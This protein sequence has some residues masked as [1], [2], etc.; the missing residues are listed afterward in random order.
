[1][2]KLALL[3][4]EL[5]KLATKFEDLR[6]H[7]TIAHQLSS[8]VHDLQPQP[9]ADNSFPVRPPGPPDSSPLKEPGLLRQ[10]GVM[11]DK[12]ATSS[13]T[14]HPSLLGQE[15]EHQ[16]AQNIAHIIRQIDHSTRARQSAVEQLLNHHLD[17]RDVPKSI[18]TFEHQ[19]ARAK[20][21]LEG[22]ASK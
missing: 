7:R 1:L 12:M 9:P 10:L 8:F 20:N 22:C 21:D 18:D 14:L 19:V 3:T 2:C 11:P 16:A 17:S 15:L 13:S 4:S 6:S 5:E